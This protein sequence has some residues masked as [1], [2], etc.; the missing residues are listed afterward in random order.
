MATRLDHA[1]T[2]DTLSPEE[3]TKPAMHIWVL[4]DRYT[5]VVIDAPAEIES[6]IVALDMRMLQAIAITSVDDELVAGAVNLAKR[7]NAFIGIP[8]LDLPLWNTKHPETLAVIPYGDG[9]TFEIGGSKLQ[10]LAT[11]GRTPGASCI[12]WEEERILLTGKSLDGE[13]S[14]ETRAKL[15]ALGPGV[16]VKRARGED[17]LLDDLLS[18]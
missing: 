16:T 4:G 18:S 7:T 14:G 8:K 1:L 3:Q 6:V 17:V 11:P 5:C 15:L 9:E 2:S 13:I 12:W 10:T